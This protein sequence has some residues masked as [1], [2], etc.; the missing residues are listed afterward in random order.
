MTNTQTPEREKVILEL[1]EIASLHFLQM[2]DFPITSGEYKIHRLQYSNAKYMAD[3]MRQH[4]DEKYE[5]R[6]QAPTLLNHHKSK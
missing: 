1:E 5:M 3:Y 2:H 4:L 6:A